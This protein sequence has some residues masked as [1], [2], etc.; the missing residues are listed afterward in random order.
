MSLNYPR[1]Y[2]KTVDCQWLVMSPI[3]NSIILNFTVFSIG[4]GEFLSIY[5]GVDLNGR[6]LNR[7]NGNPDPFETWINTKSLYMT[8][9]PTLSAPHPGFNI[10]LLTF[11][12]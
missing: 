3:T 6:L 5:E 1:K 10:T 7:Y 8:F 11:G 4:G 9:E 12:K 2:D